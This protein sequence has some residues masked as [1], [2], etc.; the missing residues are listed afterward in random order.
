MRTTTPA[1]LAYGIRFALEH[2]T[3]DPADRLRLQHLLC[4]WDAQER[5][6]AVPGAAIVRQWITDREYFLRTLEQ[7]DSEAIAQMAEAAAVFC[8]QR[9]PWSPVTV[10][11][12]LAAWQAAAQQC[13]DRG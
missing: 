11:Q 9:V 7:L 2:G 12:M 4:R 13:A 1:D 5:R 8:A 3:F 6:P 10:D